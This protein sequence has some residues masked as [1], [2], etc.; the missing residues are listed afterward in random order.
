MRL[1]IPA[2]SAHHKRQT[3]ERRAGALDRFTLMIKWND[4]AR[5][6]TACVCALPGQIL[7]VTLMRSVYNHIYALTEVANKNAAQTLKEISSS[8]YYVCV[9]LAVAATRT[10][11]L[12]ANTLVSVTSAINYPLKN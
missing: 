2:R 11:F 6:W 4:T 12:V 10:K 9:A 7:A 8:T 1:F 3:S 5:I